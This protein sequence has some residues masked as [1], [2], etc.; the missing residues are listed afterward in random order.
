[1]KLNKTND[2]IALFSRVA[3]IGALS[4]V[5]VACGSGDE[6]AVDTAPS[7]RTL[8]VAFEGLEA[9]GDDYVYEGWVIVD[10]KPVTTGRFT[11]DENGVPAPAEFA[12]PTDIADAA[13]VFVLTIEPTVD[14]DPGPS[15]VHVLG[16]SF[17]DGAADLSIGH[18]AALGTDLV[19]AS[20]GFILKTPTTHDVDGDDSQGIWWLQLANKKPAA[21]LWLPELPDGWVYEGWVVGDDGPI[22]TGRF[23]A[24]DEKD[25]DGAGM[26]AGPDG[27]PMFAGQD[28][29]AP[30]VDLIG[31]AAVISVE[32]EPDNNPMPFALKP[33]INPSIEDL[34]G[35]VLQ[36][37]ENRSLHHTITGSAWFQ[38][39]K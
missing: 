22:S 29:I 23:K 5:L 6:S 36:A 11:V 17:E 27:F 39:S 33:L 35:G 26:T 9:L 32:P 30:P 24:A 8:G 34:G 37:M 19:D 10:G 7:T 1:V 3:L 4:M 13:D 31:H 15:H 25:S 21:S 14:D 2:L 38:A 16:G 28:F 18:K 12:I 20:G